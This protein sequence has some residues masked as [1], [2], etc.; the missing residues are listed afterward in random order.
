ME[1][2]RLVYTVDE[3]AKILGISRVLAYKCVAMN[4]IP[5]IRIGHCIRIPKKEF[6]MWLED[7]AAGIPAIS[8]QSAQH[9]ED[10]YHETKRR[11]HPRYVTFEEASIRFISAILGDEWAIKV[12]RK[13][14]S[15]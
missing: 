2:K 7:P 1:N 12:A 9:I 14:T 4:Q 11:K 3:I 6:H 15:G 8:N 13:L 5:H 10:I